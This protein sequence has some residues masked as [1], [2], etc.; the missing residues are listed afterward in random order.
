GSEEPQS[1][2]LAASTLGSETPI[3]GESASLH[4]DMNTQAHETVGAERLSSGVPSAQEDSYGDAEQDPLSGHLEADQEASI[5]T[6]PL[7]DAPAVVHPVDEPPPSQSEGW[8]SAVPQPPQSHEAQSAESNMPRGEQ[9]LPSQEPRVWG[10]AL[11]RRGH[12]LPPPP[13]PLAEEWGRSSSK[14]KAEELKPDDQSQESKDD[15]DSAEV[16]EERLPV[17]S[18]SDLEQLQTLY[19]RFLKARRRCG[20]QGEDPSFESFQRQIDRIQKELEARGS[21]HEGLRFSVRIKD[22]RVRLKVRPLK[23]T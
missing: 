13:G 14:R 9:S 16:A 19:G 6:S 7:I 11:Q 5:T 22:G 12:S 20:E 3:E 8:G 10:A 1:V 18:T 15:T 23:S 2:A 21:T 4:Q 17:S